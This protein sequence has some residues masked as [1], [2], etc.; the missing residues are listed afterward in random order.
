[1]KK[2]VYIYPSL[3]IVFF[4][5]ILSNKIIFLSIIKNKNIIIH[6]SYHLLVLSYDNK[7]YYPTHHRLTQTFIFPLKTSQSKVW[8]INQIE[9][10]FNLPQT[11]LTD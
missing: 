4:S 2:M 10:H 9:L 8:S 3:I 5:K 7:S 1:M 6:L 11:P